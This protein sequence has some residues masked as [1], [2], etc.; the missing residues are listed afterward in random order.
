MHH[1]KLGIILE[2]KLLSKIK[3]IKKCQQQKMFSQTKIIQWIKI[4][5]DWMILTLKINL[6]VRFRHV[7]TNRMKVSQKDYCFYRFFTKI[8]SQSYLSWISTTYGHDKIVPLFWIYKYLFCFIGAVAR[9]NGSTK[10][11]FNVGWTKSRKE[12][13]MLMLNV[14]S[15][16]QLMSYGFPGPLSSCPFLIPEICWYRECVLL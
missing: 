16:G 11:A 1:Q 10:P 7:L 14:R 15:V 2:N 5:K 12:T 4:K 13:Q 8:Y 9:Q 3:V 6:K